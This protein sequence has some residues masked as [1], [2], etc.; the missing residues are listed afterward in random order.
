MSVLPLPATARYRLAV[1]RVAALVPFGIA[2]AG[3][4]VVVW[5]VHRQ[6]V[7]MPTGS[8]WIDTYAYLDAVGKLFHSPVHLYDAARSQLTSAAAQRAFLYPP[9]AL[10][11]FLPLGLVQSAFGIATAASIW[12]IVDA[13]ALMVAVLLFSRQAHLGRWWTALVLLLACACSP[14]LLE[15]GSGQVNGVLL[16]LVALAC[17]ESGSRREALWLGLA[18]AL[19]PVAPLLLLVPLCRR[20]Y[21]NTL[22]AAGIA[23]GLNIVMLPLVGFGNEWFYV[24]TFLPFLGSHVVSDLNNLSP[25]NALQ[26]LL[27]GRPIAPS[28]PVVLGSLHAA[29]L[30]ALL[31]SAERLVIA[32]LALLAMFRTRSDL[33]AVAIAL[34]VV[35]LMAATAWGHYYVL[36]LPLAVF[37]VARLNW[38]RRLYFFAMV[39][40]LGISARSG[41][42]WLPKIQSAMSAGA[43]LSMIHS[44]LFIA[45]CWVGVAT[46]VLINIRRK[47]NAVPY[48]EDAA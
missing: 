16:L 36:L 21:R 40:L 15:I 33:T 19:K 39:L 27:G 26:I 28:N 29:T 42:L 30:A 41:G 9:S 46:V 47:A 32:G 35:P 38:H 6:I 43:V 25:S 20:R 13:T 34:A 22:L 37:E 1:N 3:I 2:F 31:G 24:T 18:V 14:T 5:A 10:I 17:R 44:L 48:L 4:A 8:G 7:G 23:V 12:V 11:P 45:F